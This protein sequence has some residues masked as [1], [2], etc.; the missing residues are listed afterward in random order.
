MV[1]PRSELNRLRR[2]YETP[3]NG[4]S[5]T[6]SQFEV[7]KLELWAQSDASMRY[8]FQADPTLRL[9]SLRYDSTYE[10]LHKEL[11][12]KGELD[13]SLA[14]CPELLHPRP[15]RVWTP[16]DGWKQWDV[17]PVAP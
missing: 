7:S 16:T 4:V 12:Q 17:Q 6:G 3:V 2:V 15:V 14:Q 5:I 10:M 11:E 9:I 13:H 8:L 1:F